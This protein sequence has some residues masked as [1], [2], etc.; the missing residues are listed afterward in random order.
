MLKTKLHLQLTHGQVMLNL[1]NNNINMHDNRQ[2]RQNKHYVVTV[3]YI[4]AFA[5]HRKLLVTV[6]DL[7][8]P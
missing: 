4:Y 5:V 8:F 2:T 6:C 3:T 1:S 7:T